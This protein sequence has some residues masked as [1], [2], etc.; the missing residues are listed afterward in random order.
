MTNWP[1]SQRYRHKETGTRAL[2]VG[3]SASLDGAQVTLD[4]LEDPRRHYEEAFPFEKVAHP[5]YADLGG[6]YLTIMS[7]SVGTAPLT[8]PVERFEAEWEPAG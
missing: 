6:P 8:I 5:M 3:W 4:C 7:V 1:H 2:V